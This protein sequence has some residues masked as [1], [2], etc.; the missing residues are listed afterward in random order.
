MK[1]A[2]KT[3]EGVGVVDNSNSSD[4]EDMDVSYDCELNLSSNLEPTSFQEVST[5][6]KRKES[7]QNEYDALMNNG[8]WKLVHPLVGIKP[9]GCKWV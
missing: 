9:I 6:D 1:W 7:M 3:L 4:V 2:T 8:T 5:C